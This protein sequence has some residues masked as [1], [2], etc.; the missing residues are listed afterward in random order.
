MQTAHATLALHGGTPVRSAPYPKHPEIGAEERT[1]V[2]E[3][4]DGGPLSGFIASSGAPFLGG[5]KVRKL[6]GAFQEYFGV[7]YAVAMNSATS[8]LHAAVAALG[9]GPGDEVIV[10]PYTM[11]ASAAAILMCNA[12]PVFAD[13]EPETFNIDPLAIEKAITPHTKAIMVVHLFG[14]PA[15]MDPIMSIA[16]AHR[17]PVIEDASQSPAARYRG[18]FAGTLGDIGIF[19]LNQN[20]T[21]TCGEG[22][23][24]VTRHAALAER[25]RLVRNHGECIVQDRPDVDIT[26]MLGWNY[27]PTELDAAVSVA[28]F[29]KLDKLTEH[30]V[31]LAEH[32]SIRLAR[33]PGLQLPPMFPDATHVYFLYA[34]KFDAGVWGIS[35]DGFVRALNAEGV[36]FGAGYVPPLYW[37]PMYQSKH[38][39]GRVGCPFRCP[40]YEGDVSYVRG[41][42]PVTER[43]HTRE[44][45]TTG[46]C[47]YPLAEADIEEAI[48][49]IEKVWTHRLE[50]ADDIVLP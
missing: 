43:M 48:Q 13:I 11:T 15:A 2:A 24:A 14:H 36:P 1:E 12:V 33:F 26:N 23:V 28:Q 21:I 31:R 4:L 41:I 39:Y 50:L 8:C 10:T 38:L 32:L 37:Q 20:K 49:A 46:I 17:L 16:R 22:G 40:H 9:C 30:R 47:R 34:M 45:V 29:Q 7:E 5:P 27:R 44:L 19:S 42:C 18:A 25:M 6:E 35:R 3:V